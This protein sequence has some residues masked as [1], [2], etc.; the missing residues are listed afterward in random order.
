LQIVA[1]IMLISSI[2]AWL[3]SILSAQ[4]P[5]E[6]SSM[7]LARL[8][9]QDEITCE[10]PKFSIWDS[11]PQNSTFVGSVE[12][13]AS[14][15]LASLEVGG[16]LTI[17]APYAEAE[18]YAET[19]CRKAGKGRTWMDCILVQVQ[20]DSRVKVDQEQFAVRC[21]NGSAQIYEEAFFNP[22]A[23]IQVSSRKTRIITLYYSQSIHYNPSISIILMDDASSAHLARNL[24]KTMKLMKDEDFFIPSRYSQTFSDAALNLELILNGTDNRSLLDVMNSMVFILNHRNCLTFVNEEHSDDVIHPLFPYDA[25]FDTRPLHAFNRQRSVQKHC[26]ATG[27][28]FVSSILDPL[29]TFSSSFRPLCTL[30]ITRFRVP[31]ELGAIDEELSLALAQLISTSSNTAIFLLSPSG[32]KR[33]GLS[34]VVEGKSPLLAAWFPDE[35]RRNRNA[36]YSA[37]AWNMDKLFTTRDVRATL[38]QLALARLP[39]TVEWRAYNEEHNQASSLLSEMLPEERN[40]TTLGIADENCLCL[41]TDEKRNATVN[42]D[43][44]LNK[45]VLELVESRVGRESCVEK[46][47]TDERWSHLNAYRMFE[48]DLERES[49]DVEWLTIEYY[50]KI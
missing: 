13:P 50:V 20:F 46:I 4:S 19:S 31:S 49:N 27:K 35:F 12:C 38:Q 41:G 5:V 48:K 18:Y 22:T 6:K 34:G 15:S 26:L 36:H 28:S 16:Y 10:W 3:T 47:V 44:L 33:A 25:H 8:Q 39:E 29:L 1:T 45:R 37:F 14:P 21:L 32:Q 23:K 9:R 17:T 40:C 42:A 11:Q 7:N 43:A 24:P 2:A 30:S